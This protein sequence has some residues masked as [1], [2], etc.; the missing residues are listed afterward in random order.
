MKSEKNQTMFNDNQHNEM[1]QKLL[2]NRLS[3]TEMAEHFSD[4]PKLLNLLDTLK[5]SGTPVKKSD[6]HAW[7]ELVAKRNATQA[8]IKPQ[9]IRTLA[10][11]LSVAAS[12]LIIIGLVV[13]FRETEIK[14]IA[15][16]GEHLTVYLPDSSQVT[17]NAETEIRYDQKS[18]DTDRTLEL[19][20]EAFFEVKKGSRFTVQT[21]NGTV[22]VL[23]TSFNTFSRANDFRAACY[24]GKVKVS[25]AV[26]VEILTPGERVESVSTG[27]KKQT[28][29][30]SE[31]SDWRNG[32]FE[33][34]SIDLQIVIDEIQRQF[35]VEISYP[36]D[37]AGRT[38]TGN[39]TNKNIDD[40]L[41]NI[42]I[43]M[44]LTY[45]MTQNKI[46]IFHQ[47]N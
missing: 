45:K 15:Q 23:G 20:G 11:T 17:L 37:L 8:R 33:Y 27:L 39:F 38:Y 21:L 34:E 4:N 32:V 47:T 25:N 22:E 19:K 5:N 2:E 44:N 12:I 3:E 31:N 14:H 9:N 1:Y 46:E 30:P 28:F 7:A 40:A 18:W 35:K 36:T 10:A 41:Q 43:P 29:K 24:T 16:A 13:L 42:C 6:E 26:D